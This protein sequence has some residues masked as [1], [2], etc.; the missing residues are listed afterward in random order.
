[1]RRHLW[2]KGAWW[3]SQQPWVPRRKHCTQMDN[4][5]GSIPQASSPVHSQSRA[6]E[7]GGNTPRFTYLLHLPPGRNILFLFCKVKQ[8]TQDS[9]KRS[10][11]L[12]ATQ[13]GCYRVEKLPPNKLMSSSLLHISSLASS[14][15]FL[16]P[17]QSMPVSLST[18][19][20]RP[21]GQREHLSCS[22]SWMLTR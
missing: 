19:L 6:Q 2:G 21:G 7:P 14:V 16:L 10:I 9:Q 15:E 18:L 13:W 11:L 22:S 17:P 3:Q 8:K 1:M 12:K 20:R 5:V 4:E